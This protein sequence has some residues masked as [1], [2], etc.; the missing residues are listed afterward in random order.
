M[1]DQANLRVEI[2]HDACVVLEGLARRGGAGGSGGP[3]CG[4]RCSH[5]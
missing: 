1:E 4:H 5:R 2:Q 3:G